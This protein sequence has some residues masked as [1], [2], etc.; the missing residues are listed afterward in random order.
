ME[1]V[2][3]E[4]KSILSEQL[5]S[6]LKLSFIEQIL[7]RLNEVQRVQF[8]FF[9][10]HNRKNLGVAYAWLIFFG[11][12]GIHKFYLQKRNAWLYLLFCWTMLPALLAVID[13]FLLPFKV[14]KHNML[15]AASLAELIRELDGNPHSLTLIDDKLSARRVPLVEWIAAI[16][17]ICL[18]ILPAVGYINM[19]LNAQHLEIHYKTNHFDGSQSDSSLVL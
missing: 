9:Y 12:F 14:R 13:L 15:L 6:Q 4:F 8:N 1:C 5:M 19:R 18:L 11:V 3:I 10:R 2:K 7:Q 16:A 17:I